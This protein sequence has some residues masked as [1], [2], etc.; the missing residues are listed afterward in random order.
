VRCRQWCKTAMEYD[1]LLRK[2]D[3]MQDFR[4]GWDDAN[5]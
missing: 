1:D 3:Q 5:H 4:E 2:T